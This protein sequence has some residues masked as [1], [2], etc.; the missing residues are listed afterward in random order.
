[1]MKDGVELRISTE[2]ER[3]ER[4]TENFDTTSSLYSLLYA[5]VI[6]REDKKVTNNVFF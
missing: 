1:M 3:K 2:E 6:K 5:I 4:R